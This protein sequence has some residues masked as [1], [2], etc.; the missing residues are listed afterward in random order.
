MPYQPAL[1]PLD[2]SRFDAYIGEELG[3]I[4]QELNS[5]D[6]VEYSPAWTAIT[7]N[8]VLGNGSL[9]A[10]YRLTNDLCEL[11]LRLLVGSTTTFGSGSWQFAM[12]RPAT[13]IPQI[14]ELLLLDVSSTTRYAGACRIDPGS[15][16]LYSI[17]HAATTPVAAAT[18]FTWAVNDEL[19]AHI[20]YFR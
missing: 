11:W 13:K 20:R 4:A 19:L 9:R 1:P 8:P 6:L 7:T 12:P 3:K 16:L 15:N 5:Y 18:P 2:P 10:L 17:T 14:G